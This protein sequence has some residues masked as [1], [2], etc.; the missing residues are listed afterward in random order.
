MVEAEDREIDLKDL[1]FKVLY[2][3]RQILLAGLIIALAAGAIKYIKTGS[4]P[5][6]AAEM[7]VVL[8]NAKTEARIKEI[9]STDF[10]T[11]EEMKD[12]QYKK[13]I[14]IIDVSEE[15]RRLE[16]KELVKRL[17]EEQDYLDNSIRMHIN[18]Y[19]KPSA[20]VEYKVTVDGS[21][22]LFR[23]PADEIVSDM[24]SG[25]QRSEQIKKIAEKYN[26]DEKYIT[27]L[28]SAETDLDGNL[29]IIEAAGTDKAMAMDIMSA[30]EKEISDREKKNLRF[31]EGVELIRQ[32]EDFSEG[33]DQK[34][35]NA[36]DRAFNQMTDGRER[37]VKNKT[38]AAQNEFDKKQ[39]TEK[40]EKYD[41][42]FAE[43]E[44]KAKE[45]EAKAEQENTASPNKVKAALKFAIIGFIA[46]MLI[47]AVCLAVAYLVKPTLRYPEEMQN[48]YG[49]LVLGAFDKPIKK[50]AIDRLIQ[51]W[52]G[53]LTGIPDE[54]VLD[55]AI[56]SIR[57]RI[58]P[59]EKI[60]IL[61][62][63][64]TGKM[65]EPGEK[66]KAAFP[67]N[68]FDMAGDVR[69]SA[70]DLQKL[71]SSDKVLLIEERDVSKM[72][73]VDYQANQ[74]ITYLK[75]VAGCMVL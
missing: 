19:N 42:A 49:Y 32:R 6:Q 52:E 62:T 35:V 16:E 14:A 18:A 50:N 72:K 4:A 71:I 57:N 46:G 15:N 63:I 5:E 24:I 26:T 12:E 65:K 22:L 74:I 11:I 37:L 75:P 40:K 47:Y 60:L 20:R 66:I 58:A 23:D 68:E 29:I 10:S 56:V 41:A 13:E 53:N 33:V 64:G 39:L 48:Y 61:G 25:L 31:L 36:Q 27:E 7:P 2:S 69:S 70:A 55:R 43:A 9:L 28:I 3:W 8:K 51:K 67:E 38:L 59:G 45:E 73:D 34:L 17:S 1:F 44:K 54:Q 21:E 30:I